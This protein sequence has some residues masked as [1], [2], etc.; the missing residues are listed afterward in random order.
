M[1]AGY[2]H[3]CAITTDDT[4][5]CWGY[6]SAG[7]LGDGPLLANDPRDV[8]CFCR[9]Q[10]DH[11]DARGLADGSGN[12]DRA[13]NP[14]ADSTECGYGNVDPGLH[15]RRDTCP[16]L[17]PVATLLRRPLIHLDRLP[18][19]DAQTTF[20]LQ[21][22]VTLTIKYTDLGIGSPG[23]GLLQM[24]YLDPS[25]GLWKNDG[26]AVIAR[27]LVNNRITVVINHLSPLCLV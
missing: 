8:R 21:R 14:A 18:V 9:D 24:F 7:R 17:R 1:D 6:N 11:R 10:S 4:V 22:P 3:T 25:D 12:A 16:A 15:L 2:A 20:A 19:G 26:I 5:M 23:E 27:D 13:R